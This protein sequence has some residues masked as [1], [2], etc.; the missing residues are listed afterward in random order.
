MSL[1]NRP[2]VKLIHL[3]R[4]RY[5]PA[6]KFQESIVNRLQAGEDNHFLILVEHDPGKFGLAIQINLILLVA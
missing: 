1:L 2:T 3:G 4:M 5:L 6:L